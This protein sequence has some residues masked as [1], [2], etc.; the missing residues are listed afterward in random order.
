MWRPDRREFLR[1]AAIASTAVACGDNSDG[2]RF[3]GFKVA[4]QSWTFRAYAIDDALARIEQL[5]VKRVELSPQAGHFGFPATDEQ[6]ANMRAKIASH[7]LDCV[8]SG[9]EPVSDDHEANRAVFEYAKRLGLRTIM[10]DAPPESL[11]S[12]D[13]LV[14]TYDIRIGIHNHGPGFRYNLIADMQAALAGRDKRIGTIVDTGHYT[15]AGED[16]VEAFHTFAGRVYGVHL[17]DVSTHAPDAFDKIVGEG[18]L[19]LVGVFKALRE[20]RFPADASLSL[21]YEANLEPY[22]DVVVCLENIAA[23]AHASW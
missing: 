20:I 3:A 9:L 5:G 10:V 17:K 8:T 1:A 2:G 14:R 22:D 18:V 7:G 23:A 6:I 21:E 13:E 16:P 12:L 11:D 15:R 19:D 4:I